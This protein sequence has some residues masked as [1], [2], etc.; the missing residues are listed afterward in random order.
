MVWSRHLRPRVPLAVAVLTAGI[1]LGASG[2][3]AQS[4]PIPLGEE[5]GP[6][7]AGTYVDTST[8]PG[9]MFSV[10]DGWE[11]SGEPIPGVGTELHPL[12]TD[13]II[14]LTTFDGNVFAQ[15]CPVKGR[16]ER[17]LKDTVSVDVT[18][19]A[20][21]GALVGN[22]SLVAQEPVS[23][24]LSGRPALQLDVVSMPGKKCDPRTAF[25][26]ELPVISEFHLSRGSIG[27]VIAADVG[28]EVVVVVIETPAQ[29]RAS[30]FDF[31]DTAMALVDTIEITP[32]AATAVPEESDTAAAPDG[33]TEFAVVLTEAGPNTIPVIKL[34]REVT[35][36]GLKDSKDMV[37]G[38]P[39]TIKEGLAEEE[40]EEIK[41][42]FEE[43]GA[44]VEIE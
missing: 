11:M 12:G 3:I 14:T 26:W 21:I 39:T 1:V 44:T 16:L 35:G 17:F 19:E 31:L 9:V 7:V 18:A 5:P 15:A 24:E 25:L 23:T 22:G 38:V 42:A 32:A 8:G 43:Q 41:A 6:L 4:E 28:D 34:V 20:F 40:A 2:A 27:R 13:G 10:G 36:L 29:T 33:T 37:D 30:P